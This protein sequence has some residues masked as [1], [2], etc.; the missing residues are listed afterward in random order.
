M[1]M[2]CALGHQGAQARDQAERQDE[3]KVPSQED[4]ADLPFCPCG[5]RPNH[6][7][8]TGKLAALAAAGFRDL[9]CDPRTGN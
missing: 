2:L 9:P 4:T 1:V 6:P 8:P 3:G 7:H 5:C